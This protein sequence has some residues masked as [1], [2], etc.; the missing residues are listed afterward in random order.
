M[1]NEDGRF[2]YQKVEDHVRGLMA[3][4]AL[5][6]GDKLPSL[7]SLSARLSV[8]VTTVSQAYADMERKG[9]VEARS[10]S[11]F[12]VRAPRRLPEPSGAPD[13]QPPRAVSRSGLIRT[14]LESVGDP[15]LTP[16][17]VICPTRDLLPGKALARI[18]A[19]VLRE[20]PE[21]A[22]EYA[23]IPGS[24]ELRKQI[25][26]RGLDHGADFGPSDVVITS[27]ALEALYIALRVATR[28]GDAV[29]IQSPTYYCFLQL[30]ETLGLRAIEI[31]SHPGRGIDPGDVADALGKFDIR[32]AIFSPNFNNPDGSLTPDEAKGEIAALL[33][34]AGAPLVEDDVYG[35]LHFGQARPGTFKAHDTDGGVILCSSFSKTIAPG[36][37][38]GW[39]VPGRFMDKALEIKATTNV[40]TASPTQMA[41]A[42]F[43][44]RGLYDKHLRRLRTAVRT[45]RDVMLHHVGLHFPE[46]TRATRP[47]G[48]AV[49][50]LELPGGV[51]GVDYFY[52]ARALGIGV[53]P[54]GIF[55]TRD[56]FGGCVRLS[57]GGVWD[58]ATE[59]AVR[60]LGE[61]AA[62]MAR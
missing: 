17:G 27:G 30:M 15:T 62:S 33:A 2:R 39:M 11:G 53:A 61:L 28:P 32:A 5:N 55:S 45:Q 50:W 36:Y 56:R 10:R 52:R 14:V 31:P 48:G 4:G 16:L 6:P 51:D 19:A 20:H 12:Y 9:L 23:P 24:L 54:G 60:T 34:A 41:V 49:L 26:L 47:E 13:A 58:Q 40:C 18:M 43:L 29:L 22:L 21:R 46:G 8:S 3:A 44:R 38:V 7:R 57:M 25:A 37:R 35:D 59:R 42:E 1:R